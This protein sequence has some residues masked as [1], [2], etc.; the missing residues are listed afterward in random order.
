M[1]T[2]KVVAF[3]VNVK[4]VE[5]KVKSN[6]GIEIV[7]SFKPQY[8]IV[9]RTWSMNRIK[10]PTKPSHDDFAAATT[11]SSAAFVMTDDTV[12]VSK[13]E[14][15]LDVIGLLTPAISEVS[16][17]IRHFAQIPVQ[18]RKALR[19]QLA[20]EH[21]ELWTSLRARKITAKSR[22]SGLLEPIN[23]TKLC[24]RH[25]YC[26]SRVTVSELSCK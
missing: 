9:E 22:S 10:R 26:S 12:D 14:D 18:S 8:M 13:A 3:S 20:Y 16:I 15:M 6:V 2:Y 25:L 1:S 4:L 24:C 21:N 5:N 19:R 23:Q 7:V 11:S 17:S